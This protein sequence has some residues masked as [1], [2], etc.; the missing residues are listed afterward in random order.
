MLYA[1][2]FGYFYKNSSDCESTLFVLYKINSKTSHNTA[3]SN[4]Q[5]SKSDFTVFPPGYIHVPVMGTMLWYGSGRLSVFVY[6]RGHLGFI[7]T[8]NFM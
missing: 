2:F 5:S 7:M 1:L 4:L 6:S 8:T 3:N